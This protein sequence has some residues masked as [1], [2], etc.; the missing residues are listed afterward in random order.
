MRNLRKLSVGPIVVSVALLAACSPDRG[1]DDRTGTPEV[2]ANAAETDADNSGLNERDRS[3]A[4]LTPLDQGGSEADRTATQSIRK[5][6][7]DEDEFSVNA[8]NVKIIT[9]D[10]VVTLRGPV[11]TAAEKARIGAITAKAEGVKR[12]DNQLEVDTDL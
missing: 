3:G 7:V 4:T 2:S 1:T 9:K 12:V 8:K 11:A 5:Q 6:I 10:G